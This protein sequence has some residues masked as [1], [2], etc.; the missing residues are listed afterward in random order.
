MLL[1][2]WVYRIKSSINR[3]QACIHALV[4]VGTYTICI[5]L[6]QTKS[7]DESNNFYKFLF[8]GINIAA[9]INVLND[10]ASFLTAAL[11]LAVVNILGNSA[12]ALPRPVINKII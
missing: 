12:A 1:F 6:D 7:A 3:P 2:I 8:A 11:L 10:Y 9:P 5:E 4:V